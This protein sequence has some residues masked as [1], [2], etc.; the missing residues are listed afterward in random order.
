MLFVSRPNNNG[1]LLTCQASRQ[2]ANNQT[3]NNNNKTHTKTDL[4]GSQNGIMTR[5]VIVVVVVVV[6]VVRHCT[7]YWNLLYKR[8]DDVC[9]AV[10]NLLSLLVALKLNVALTA[11][12]RIIRIIIIREVS[13][14]TI[15]EGKAVGWHDR[16]SITATCALDLGAMSLYITVVYCTCGIQYSECLPVRIL[17]VVLYPTVSTYCI[18]FNRASYKSRTAYVRR[19]SCS[20]VN[21]S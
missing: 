20:A 5:I 18:N 19:G 6:A 10:A 15:T 9:S 13:K 8:D 3:S 2:T 21:K 12:Y 16:P 14:R 11:K 4:P 7:V 17:R 1:A